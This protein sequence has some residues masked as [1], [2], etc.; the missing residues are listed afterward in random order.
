MPTT[1]FSR[2]ARALLLGVALALCATSCSRTL[3]TAATAPAAR[4]QTGANDPFAVSGLENQV[5]V[6]L[7]PGVSPYDLAAQYSATVVEADLGERTAALRPLPGTISPATLM[8]A[9]QVDG[10][11]ETCEPNGWF[12]PAEARQQSFAFDDGFGSDQTYKEQPV[13]AALNLDHAHD[14]AMGAGV[15]VAI[16]DTGCDLKHPDLRRSIVGGWDFVDND[17]DP[18]DVKDNID[19]NRNGVIDEAFGHGTH[20]AGIVHLVAPDAQLLIVRVLDADGRGNIVDV[21]AGVR[22]AVQHG[23]K[24]INLSLGVSDRSGDALQDAMEEAM[25]QGVVIVSAAGNQASPNVDFPGRSDATVCVAAVD[26]AANGASFSSFNHSDV[27]LSAPGIAVRSTYPGGTYR[28]WS[29]TSMSAPFVTGTAALLAEK[30]PE[31]GLAA[32][33]AR[34]V[35]TC[36]ALKSVPT[37]TLNQPAIRDFGAGALDVGAALSPDFVPGPNRDPGGETI[38]PH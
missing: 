28:L 25:A 23:A 13:T 27:V 7:A 2:P 38:R 6:T 9:L 17:A 20:V 26:A 12:T 5:V 30:H 36:K 11:T 15:K 22:W 31:W 37:N 34:L 24:V 33:E 10:R 29:G 1:C 3:P 19:N 21:A 14:I 4:P 18:T 16:I 8:S 32:M 35:A